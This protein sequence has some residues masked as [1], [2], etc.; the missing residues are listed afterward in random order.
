M[1]DQEQ[2][3]SRVKKL[4]Q[5]AS[6]NPNENEA[7]AALAKMHALLK[8]HDLDFS[9]VTQ[10]AKEN[11]EK[12]IEQMTPEVT[13]YSKYE[14]ALMNAVGI[15]CNTKGI[16]GHGRVAKSRTY[17]YVFIAFVGSRIDVAVS[18][19]AWNW[20]RAQAKS[21]SVQHLGKGSTPEHRN[22]CEGFSYRIFAR[23]KAI[24]TE[25]NKSEQQENKYA[26]IVQNKDALI[27]KY[28]RDTGV[29]KGRASPNRGSHDHAS[30]DLG[31]TAGEKVNLNFRNSI[32]GS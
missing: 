26:L 15:L 3:L 9:S 11:E 24:K 18:I 27:Q 25:R 13:Q 4:F 8:E 22:F 32:S 7:N 19:E 30:F 14:Y 21:L 31:S 6:N 16:K 10:E 1:D 28:F 12:I 23:A 17:R 5:L 20:L 2:I 29:K